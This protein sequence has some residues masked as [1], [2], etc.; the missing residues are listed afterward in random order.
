MFNPHDVITANRPGFTKGSARFFS[1]FIPSPS[2]NVG[3]RRALKAFSELIGRGKARCLIIG[4]GE[5]VEFNRY[6]SGVF[7]EIIISD[8]V[9]GP[10]VIVVCDGHQL[11]FENNT[12]D[13]IFLIAVLEHVIDPRRVIAEVTRTLKYDGV[14]LVDAPFMQQVHMVLQKLQLRIS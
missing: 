14:I 5:D 13:C 12:F 6:A 9:L 2:I 3:G 7:E 10:E 11:P 1:R 8:V 4:S